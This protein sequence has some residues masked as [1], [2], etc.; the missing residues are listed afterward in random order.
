MGSS[1]CAVQRVERQAD[2]V[3]PPR[4]AVASRRYV[5]HRFCVQAN[6]KAMNWISNLFSCLKCIQLEIF[7]RRSITCQLCGQEC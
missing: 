4:P 5:V 7:D 6:G 3:E 1:S 2:L